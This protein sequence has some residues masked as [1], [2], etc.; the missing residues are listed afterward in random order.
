MEERQ[1]QLQPKYEYAY[2]IGCQIPLSM[3][4]HIN[5]YS[6]CNIYGIKPFT[7][8]GIYSAQWYWGPFVSKLTVT[9]QC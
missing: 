9:I 1:K 6:V 2:V 3:I 5:I 7:I 8:C 4:V